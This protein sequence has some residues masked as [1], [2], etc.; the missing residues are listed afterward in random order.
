M[1]YGSVKYGQAF[2]M[3]SVGCIMGELLLKRAVFT[4]YSPVEV[5]KKIHRIC[6]SVNPEEWP[7]VASLP[8][9]N[10]LFLNTNQE[11][12]VTSTFKTE[13]DLNGSSADLLD[14]LFV[15]NP[16]HRLS[17]V[18]ALHHWTY[19]TDPLPCRLEQVL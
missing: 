19:L 4:G 7:Q 13:D 15:Y 11:R 10:N 12:K 3:W 9:Y 16:E 14:K 5:L 6:G 2:D 8:L 18:D 17:A 1:L